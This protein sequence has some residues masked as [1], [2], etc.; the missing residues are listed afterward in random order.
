MPT[1]APRLTSTAAAAVA[2]ADPSYRVTTECQDNYIV[3][4]NATF[5]SQDLLGHLVQLQQRAMEALQRQDP[6]GGGRI[7]SSDLG[8]GQ[9]KGFPVASSLGQQG[10]M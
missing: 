2:A 3:L 9:G 8:P 6:S 10:I 1:Q 7:A 4:Q 5:K